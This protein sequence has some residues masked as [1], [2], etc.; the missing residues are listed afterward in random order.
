MKI[1]RKPF[2][3][4]SNC[5]KGLWA[6]TGKRRGN[7]SHSHTEITRCALVL[8]TRVVTM[9][10]LPRSHSLSAYTDGVN[11]LCDDKFN[12]ENIDED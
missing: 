4:L 12:P 11:N 5:R 8:S 1:P 6:A 7:Y 2:W 10:S 3:S 9:P